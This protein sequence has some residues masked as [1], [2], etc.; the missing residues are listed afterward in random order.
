M[1]K[2]S[3]AAIGIGVGAAVVIAVVLIAGGAS[4][5]SQG[6]VQT[7]RQQAI[8]NVTQFFV[9]KE[10]AAY[11]IRFS[12]QDYNHTLVS[13]D[14]HVR[15][16]ISVRQSKEVLYQTEFDVKSYDFRMYQVYPPPMTGPPVYAYAWILDVSEVKRPSDNVTPPCGASDLEF[17]LPDG[18]T[19]K[20]T[21][22]CVFLT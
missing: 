1:R 19:L 13:S 2:G 11:Q 16:S 15:F 7:P 4:F 5:T 20:A 22:S 3:K 9:L 14:G 12:L 18:Q 6:G 8:Q 17:T 21:V 10:G